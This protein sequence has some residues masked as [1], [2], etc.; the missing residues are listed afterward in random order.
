MKLENISLILK[1][2]KDKTGFQNTG[3]KFRNSDLKSNSSFKEEKY[4]ATKLQ[5][6]NQDVKYVT[7]NFKC[8]KIQYTSLIIEL[9]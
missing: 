9:K 7:S 5:I 4:L 8:N 3:C 1:K 2:K 6:G